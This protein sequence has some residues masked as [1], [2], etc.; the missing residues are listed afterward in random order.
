MST[1]KR[2]TVVVI[3]GIG[4]AAAVGFLA[5]PVTTYPGIVWF[6]V[7][8]VIGVLCLVVVGYLDDD[9]IDKHGNKGYW[10]KALYWNTSAKNNGN[11]KS[12]DSPLD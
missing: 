10:P 1:L 7:S 9:F 6:G 12:T 5:S 2:A 4:V 8:I 11:E 3:K